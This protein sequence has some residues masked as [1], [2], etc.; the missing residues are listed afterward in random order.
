VSS[1]A[2]GQYVVKAV[3]ITVVY[4]T[5]PFQEAKTPVAAAKIAKAYF[6]LN[7]GTNILRSVGSQD[8]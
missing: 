6:M 1:V 5:V 8:D 3:T 7:N 4:A 2:N